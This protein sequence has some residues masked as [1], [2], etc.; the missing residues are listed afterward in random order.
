MK[1]LIAV[2]ALVCSFMPSLARGETVTVRGRV[3]DEMGKPA[4]GVEV[5]S[6]WN[7][8]PEGQW[9]AYGS[10]KTDQAGRFTLECELQ[11]RDQALLA[12]DPGHKLGGLATVQVKQPDKELQ[13]NLSPLVEVRG[14]F[15]CTESGQAPGWANV[16]MSI[17][18]GGL[19]I[20]ACGTSDSKFS[21]RLPAGLYQF[22]GYGSFTDYVGVKKEVT[23]E[24]GR[25]LDMGAVDLKQTPIARSYGKSLPAWHV[26]AARDLKQDVTIADFKG[27][28][29]VVEFWGFWCGP[30]VGDSL[31]TWIDFYEDHAADRGKFEVIAFHD[32]AAKDFDQLDAKLKP[33]I[34]K[35]WAGR[36]LPFPIL[37]DTTRETIESWGIRAFPTVL[38]VDPDGHLVRLPSRVSADEYLA[39]KLTPLPP[40][41]R[42]ARL[43]DRGMSLGVTDSTKLADQ[44]AFLAR[45][46]RIKIQLD[47]EELKAAGVDAGRPLGL[48]LGAKLSLRAWLNLS[49]APFGLT[50]VEH[51]DGLKVVRRTP[52]NDMLRGPRRGRSPRTSASR[53]RSKSPWLSTSAACRS[54]EFWPVS[55]RRQKRASLSIPASASRA[56]SQ[57]RSRSVALTIRNR[58]ASHSSGCSR[59]SG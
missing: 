28:W 1:S 47:P 33:I 25:D 12:I 31:P 15:T 10:N 17:M 57:A 38:L 40:Q 52:D 26:T 9:K 48:E 24:A 53:N 23:L 22:H 30:C 14:Q 2:A 5:A 39:S 21:L 13:I 58:W 56:R 32:P 11:S 54:G 8:D 36:P 34:A 51:A 16:Y 19:R 49:L 46:G 45:A 50:Y 42:L 20:V 29:V 44:V 41:Y 35:T 55:K 27:K 6:F 3:V 18:P 37:L 7:R 43:L 4:G 59:L